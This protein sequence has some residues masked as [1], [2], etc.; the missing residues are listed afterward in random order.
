MSLPTQLYIT[1]QVH[2]YN[3]VQVHNQMLLISRSYYIHTH[4]QANV[5]YSHPPIHTIRTFILNT[6][7]PLLHINKHSAHKSTAVHNCTRIKISDT[8]TTVRRKT[9][10]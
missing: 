6:I 2:L 4:G 1:I 3:Y 5:I 9:H 8:K 10:L 7:A